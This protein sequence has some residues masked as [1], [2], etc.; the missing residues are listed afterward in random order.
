L[1]CAREQIGRDFYCRF[2]FFFA[3]LHQIDEPIIF[4]KVSIFLHRLFSAEKT[5]G[6]NRRYDFVA[7]THSKA[8]LSFGA[9]LDHGIP[10]CEES[11]VTDSIARAA[12]NP[13]RVS[14]GRAPT[15]SKRFLAPAAVIRRAVNRQKAVPTG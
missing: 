9:P 10:L 2:I 11:R 15:R 12:L 4:I 1:P 7:V 13:S 5:C 14:F 8:L 3:L 6:E